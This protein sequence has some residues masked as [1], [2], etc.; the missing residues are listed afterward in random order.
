MPCPDYCHGRPASQQQP[1]MVERCRS[2]QAQFLLALMLPRCNIKWLR[3]LTHHQ[4]H[5]G[6]EM[7]P[8]HKWSGQLEAAGFGHSCT[9]S[10]WHSRLLPSAPGFGEVWTACWNYLWYCLHYGRL[11][12]TDLLQVIRSIPGDP[13]SHRLWLY[14]QHSLVLGSAYRTRSPSSKGNSRCDAQHV[15][16]P[17]LY[18]CGLD[19][20]WRSSYT[21]FLVLEVARCCTAFMG[22][23]TAGSSLL[24]SRVSSMACSEQ[25]A[26][27]GETDLD[28]VSLQRPGQ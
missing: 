12:W 4:P 7:V 28:R 11:G 19:V 13:F 6:P 20:L 2:A 15:L 23:D 18:D 16:V 9:L 26:R 1:A 21:C 8:G 22:C 17:R 10:R 27:D 5:S 25:Y 14:H 3:Q 24:L